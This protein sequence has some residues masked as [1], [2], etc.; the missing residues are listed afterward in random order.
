MYFIFLLIKDES[1][2]N[3]KVAQIKVIYYPQYR[4]Y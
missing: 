1:E 4:P 2:K 3:W